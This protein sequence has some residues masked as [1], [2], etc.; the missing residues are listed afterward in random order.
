MC[1]D[2]YFSF[3]YCEKCECD[4]AGTT[5]KICD[6]NSAECFC[7]KNAIGPA[8][9]MCRQ[10]TFNLQE[11]DEDGC[12]QCFCFGKTSRCE[13]S[14]LI[15]TQTVDMR[16]WGLVTID[17]TIELNVSVL[18]TSLHDVNDETIGADLT[19]QNLSNRSVYFASPPAY[20]GKKLTTYGGVLNYSIFYTSGP[21]GKAIRGADVILQS[22]N[23][24]ISHYSMEQPAAAINFNG[25]VELVDINFELPD[26][27]PAK[28]EHVMQVL[29]DLR[30][31]YIRASYWTDSITTRLSNVL[32]DDA[33]PYSSYYQGD[34]ESLDFASSVE[35]CMCPENYQGL[36]CEECAPGFYRST[37]PFGG[38]CV[39][40]QCNG[41]ADE[42]DVN[43]G[44]CM[45]SA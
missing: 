11:N 39:P 29:K 16:D 19:I 34:I 23:M 1:D 2:G 30:G 35:R 42:C 12:T 15:R 22:S 18:N 43:T 41:H 45:V 44:K 28:R 6:K 20:L 13:S 14:G 24:Y 36:S 27:T 8:C 17:E 33:V 4:L 7:K 37:G 26:G 32:M 3:P 25:A 21:S 40:C 10:G 9:N 31:L 5:H 38:Y